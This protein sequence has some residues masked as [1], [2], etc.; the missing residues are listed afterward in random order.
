MTELL[1]IDIKAETVTEPKIEIKTVSFSALE[2]FKSCPQFFNFRYVQKIKAPQPLQ[3][4][5]LVGSWTH[6]LI[7][8]Y[9]NNPDASIRELFNVYIYDWVMECGVNLDS[10]NIEKLKEISIELSNLL[11]RASAFCNDE[12]KIRNSNG[13]VLKSPI[14]YPSG[15]LKKE[16]SNLKCWHYRAELDQIAC[17]ANPEFLEMSFTWLFAE[18]LFNA[19]VFKVPQ[20]IA[21]TLHTEL[22]FGTKEDKLVPLAEVIATNKNNKVITKHS[23]LGYIDWVVELTDGRVAIIDHKTSSKM[24]TSEEVLFHPQLNLYAYAYKMLY[25]KFPDIIGI[26]HIK[27]GNIVLAEVS[28]PIVIETLEYYTD[29]YITSQKELEK[30]NSGEIRAVRKHPNDYQSPCVKRDYQTGV[31]TSV[32][33]Y[34]DRCWERYKNILNI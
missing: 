3:K 24:P 5:L 14:E 9:L 7:E 29:L 22:D 20:W 25:G 17:L 21:K 28:I 2:S 31:I 19:S 34:L 13:T 11:Y 16:F 1:T 8:E 27:S 12:S 10:E 32:C 18:A 6:K 33:P 15:S 26:N 23:L 30:E 4:A